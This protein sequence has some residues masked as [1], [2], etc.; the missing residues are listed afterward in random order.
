MV[1]VLVDAGLSIA[2][3]VA[4]AGADEAAEAA[5]EMA[6]ELGD[7]GL[8]T[9]D[10]VSLGT[11]LADLSSPTQAELA[12]AADVAN[13]EGP[14]AEEAAA[15]AA[16][17]GAPDGDG[18]DDDDDKVDNEEPIKK[19]P[20]WMDMWRN[21]SNFRRVLYVMDQ[22]MMA[23]MILGEAL[24]VCKS[25]NQNAK[26]CEIMGKIYTF[27]NAEQKLNNL[28]PYARYFTETFNI[29]MDAL[30]LYGLWEEPSM[31]FLEVMQSHTS[32][33]KIWKTMFPIFY[34]AGGV[35]TSFTPFFIHGAPSFAPG[36]NLILNVTATCDLLKLDGQNLVPI[37]STPV[38]GD[39]LVMVS[40]A[41]VLAPFSS[42]NIQMTWNI[43]P[44]NV[45]SATVVSNLTTHKTYA[46]AMVPI[47]DT[48]GA[49]DVYIGP[50][51]QMQASF[52]WML[53]ASVG[54]PLSIQASVHLPF[55]TP[56][57]S[58]MLRFACF[59]AFDAQDWVL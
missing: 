55:S 49:M 14:A 2:M 24:Q 35:G 28:S 40:R 4:E 20:S 31:I 10:L 57:G 54:T 23:R 44:H 15:E 8:S 26:S 18:E 53:D 39:V 5:L 45:P 9:P 19:K 12:I 51:G 7:T 58:A 34:K 33:E 38:A 22:L 29:G 52:R 46:N 47:F 43:D 6:A 50:G 11:E 37:L 3:W 1:S 59:R 32:H 17:D 16:E 21:L 42:G 13:S 48:T 41:N 36:T 25:A 30:S 56:A 27:D